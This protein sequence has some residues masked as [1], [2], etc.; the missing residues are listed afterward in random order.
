M[1]LE[2]KVAM[3][4]ADGNATHVKPGESYLIRNAIPVSWKQEGFLRKFYITYEN[5]NAP[6]PVVSIIHI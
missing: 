5:P 3:M 4:D 2:G 1:V 6:K